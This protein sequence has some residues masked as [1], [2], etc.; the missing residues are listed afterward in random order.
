MP[1]FPSINRCILMHAM[2]APAYVSYSDHKQLFCTTE[3]VLL[4]KQTWQLELSATC[5]RRDTTEQ[6]SGRNPRVRVYQ[7]YSEAEGS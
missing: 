5:S 2:T 1:L 4:M 3:A 7:E 6:L